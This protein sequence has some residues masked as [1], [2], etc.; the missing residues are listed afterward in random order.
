[1]LNEMFF[2]LRL[3]NSYRKHNL[4]VA[5]SKLLHHLENVVLLKELFFKSNLDCQGLNIF[6]NHPLSVGDNGLP[7]SGVHFNIA[8]ANNKYL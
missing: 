7:V 1:M 3:S 2:V 5:S 8:N 4:C 6:S